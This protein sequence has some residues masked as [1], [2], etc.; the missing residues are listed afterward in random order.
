MYLFFHL[1]LIKIWSYS[2][3]CPEM[4]F[5]LLSLSPVNNI[6]S[7]KLI[8]LMRI[9]L[10][11]QLCSV[12]IKDMSLMTKTTKWLCAQ[13]RLRSAWASAWRMLGSLCT[14]QRTAKTLIRLGGRMS[15]SLATHWADSEDSD[16]TGRMPRQIWVFAGRTCHFVMKRLIF[17]ALLLWGIGTDFAQITFT[18]F[19]T[20]QAN[21]CLRAFRHDKF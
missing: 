15:G 10:E 4:I 7:R 20:R 11:Q 16:Q 2:N 13:R 1:D 18:I 8:I 19:V 17:H 6:I 5:T 9:N 12:C 14:T 3:T 21:L